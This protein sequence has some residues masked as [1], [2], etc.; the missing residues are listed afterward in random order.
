MLEKTDSV[1]M[2][3]S[4]AKRKASL[5]NNTVSAKNKAKRRAKNKAARKARKRK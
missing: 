5:Y 2:L 1:K 3:E 4:L